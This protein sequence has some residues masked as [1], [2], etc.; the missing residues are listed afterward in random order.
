MPLAVHLKM[1][2]VGILCYAYF[3]TIKKGEHEHVGFLIYYLPLPKKDL[4]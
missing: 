3:S 4:W 2:E 1:V